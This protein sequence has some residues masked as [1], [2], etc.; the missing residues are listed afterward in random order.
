[1]APQPATTNIFYVD[2]EGPMGTRTF[3]L[4]FADAVTAVEA[5]EVVK[6][7]INAALVPLWPLEVS[8]TGFRWRAKGTTVSL[9]VGLQGLTYVGTDSANLTAVDFPR[10]MSISG[11]GGSRGEQVIH[12]VY[13]GVFLTPTNYR[14]VAGDSS[15]AD[16]LLNAMP[17]VIAG[18]GFRT[19]SGDTPSLRPYVN[20]GFNSY[21]E[22][23]RRREA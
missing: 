5:R 2:Y 3:Q 22:R 16:A 14:Y 6:A 13:G 17:A 15:K 20:V 7:Y 19:D 4:R 8:V 23:R 9:P 18:G 11:R 21:F 12:F 1:M 10:F